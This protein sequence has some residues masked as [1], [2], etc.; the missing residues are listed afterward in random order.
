MNRCRK[1]TVQ[2]HPL[3]GTLR[4][5]FCSH[6]SIT[7]H[8]YLISKKLIIRSAEKNCHVY[9]PSV[10]RGNQKVAIY[11]FSWI[12]CIINLLM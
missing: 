3:H 8:E 2:P 6:A 1:S 5:C 12:H 11:T 10:V 4:K 7:N 9:T